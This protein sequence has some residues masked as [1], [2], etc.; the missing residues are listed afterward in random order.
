M[1]FQEGKSF[2]EPKVKELV[3]CAIECV[4]THLFAPGLKIHIR[5]A[6]EKGASREE[7][8]EVFELASLMGAQTVLAGVEVLRGAV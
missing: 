8:M 2:L 3:D 1:P 7:V 6:L 5:N 4:T